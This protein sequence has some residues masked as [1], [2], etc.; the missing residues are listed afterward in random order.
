MTSTQANHYVVT[1]QKIW[2]SRAEH[3]DLM[4][5]LAR[6]TPR[7]QAARRSDGLSL[8]LVDLRGADGLTIRPIRTSRRRRSP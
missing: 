5:L 4:L 1:G 6:T 2:T 7:E 8:F 3:S